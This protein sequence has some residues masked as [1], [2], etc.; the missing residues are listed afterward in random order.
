MEHDA[1]AVDC[2]S[3]EVARLLHVTPSEGCDQIDDL[4]PLLWVA[5]S[6]KALRCE[7]GLVDFSN[8]R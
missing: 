5:K 4:L 6:G 1:A 2:L 8:F 7:M 3:E